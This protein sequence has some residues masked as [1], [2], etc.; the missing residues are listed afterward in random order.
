LNEI[1]FVIQALGVVCNRALNVLQNLTSRNTW[2]R[3]QTTPSTK[4]TLKKTQ[5]IPAFFAK[6]EAAAI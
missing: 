1:E 3:V 5:L 2:P 6:K 4:I